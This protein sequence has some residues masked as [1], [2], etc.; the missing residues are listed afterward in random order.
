[1]PNY[2]RAHAPGGMFFFT[3]VTE[4]RAPIFTDPFARQHL[5]KALAD[6]RNRWPFRIDAIVLLPDHLHTHWSLPRADTAYS[7]RWA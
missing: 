5:R 3:L 6:C 1:M 7:R 4:G 2:R